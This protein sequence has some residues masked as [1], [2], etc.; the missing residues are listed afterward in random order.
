MKGN[1]V[2]MNNIVAELIWS[3]NMCVRN[4]LIQF[5][6]FEDIQTILSSMPYTLNIIDITQLGNA[7]GNFS[8]RENR[9]FTCNLTKQWTIIPIFMDRFIFT[10]IY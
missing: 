6:N 3:N 4:S 1:R 10:L 8:Q 9:S 2:A 5:Y 7:L